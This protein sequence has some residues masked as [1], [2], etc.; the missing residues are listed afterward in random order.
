MFYNRQI[1]TL[2]ES[3]KNCIVDFLSFRTRFF[4]PPT[5]VHGLEGFRC[6]INPPPFWEHGDTHQ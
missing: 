6:E 2:M 4:N 1:F 3:T 5:Q